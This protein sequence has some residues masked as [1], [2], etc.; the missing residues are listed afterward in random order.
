MKKIRLFS[1]VYDIAQLY[2]ARKYNI[3]TVHYWFCNWCL[4]ECIKRTV[5]T[6]LLRDRNSPPFYPNFFV[7]KTSQTKR[8]PLF[9]FKR[10]HRKKMPQQRRATASPSNIHIPIKKRENTWSRRRSFFKNV[11]EFQSWQTHL[12]PSSLE[13]SFFPVAIFMAKT[14]RAS[15]KFPSLLSESGPCVLAIASWHI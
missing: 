2:F 6:E 12:F 3:C 9:F 1:T 4:N 13:I 7:S 10:W 15:P 5:L 11:L 14:R 8:T